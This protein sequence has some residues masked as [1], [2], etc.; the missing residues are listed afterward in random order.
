MRCALGNAFLPTTLTGYPRGG[1][2]PGLPTLRAMTTPALIS[3]RYRLVEEIG[4]GG[5]GVVYRAEDRLTRRQVALKRVVTE[6]PLALSRSQEWSISASGS[7]MFTVVGFGVDSA[8]DADALALAHEFRFLA[9]L[10]HPNIISVLDFGF[11]DHNRPYF[12]MDWL[13]DAQDIVSAAKGRD[14]AGR[15]ELVV[16]LLRA[17]V[18]LHRRGIVHRDLKPSNILVGTDGQVKVL[19]FGI[20]VQAEVQRQEVGVA[21]TAAYMAPEMLGEAPASAVADLYSVGTIMYEM[22]G[23]R[24]A[25]DT[26]SISRLLAQVVNVTPD[27]SL[28]QGSG[29]DDALVPIITRLMSKAPEARYRTAGQTLLAVAE[30]IGTPE[31]A[32]THDSR[33]SL[34]Q[35]ARF[36]GRASELDQL[37]S[38]WRETR[39]DNRTR[40]WLVG[41]E[42]GV[43]KSRLMDE[44]RVYALVTGALVIRGQAVKDAS[45]SYQLWREAARYLALQEELT[46]LDKSVLQAVVPDIAQIVGHPVPPAPDLEAQSAQE[47][48]QRLLV[49]LLKRFTQPTLLI[50]E[51]LQWAGTVSL[52]LLRRAAEEI[53]DQPL[54]I[55]ANYRADEAPQIRDMFVQ[56][57]HMALDR[58]AREQIANLTQ[59]MLGEGDASHTASIV[60]LLHLETSGNAFYV[61][62]AI[63]SL[64]E[65]AGGLENIART[66]ITRDML[67]GALKNLVG[68]RLKGVAPDVGR[69][70]QLAAVH[71]REL[72]IAVLTAL[73]E[74]PETVNRLLGAAIENNIITVAENQY[75]FAHDKIREGVLDAVGAPQRAAMHERLAGAI[76]S[77]HADTLP[78]WAIA[79]AYHWREAGT[80][81]DKEAAYA[82]AAGRQLVERGS[83]REAIPQLTHA[84]DLYRTVRTTDEQVA[85][86]ERA[87][88]EAYFS[89]GQMDRAR[90]HLKR[91]AGLLGAPFP[92]SGAGVLAG[93]IGETVKQ[94]AHRF[95]PQGWFRRRPAAAARALEASLCYERLSHIIFFDNQT[96]PLLYASLRSLNLAENAPPSAEAAR[97]YGT[98]CYSVG[99]VPNYPLAHF[100]D[101]K[102]L[103]VASLLESQGKPVDPWVWEITAYFYSS[104]GDFATA[105]ERYKKGAESALEIGF[106]SRWLECTTLLEMDYYQ[107]GLFEKSA[108][109]REVVHEH[110]LK[111]QNEQAMG[112]AWLGIAEYALL[113]G[114]V[115]KADEFLVKARRVTH[116]MGFTERA[117]M[118]GLVA[119]LH[120][121]RGDY[122][123]MKEATGAALSLLR[124]VPLPNAYY[125]QEGYTAVAE[126][127]L[128]MAEHPEL[129]EADKPQLRRDTRLAM[130]RLLGFGWS[131]P[132]SR[133]HVR[134][135][136]GWRA[137]QRGKQTAARKHWELALT[138]A[139]KFGKVFEKGLAHLDMGRFLPDGH[140][141]LQEAHDIFTRLKFEHHRSL[142]AALIAGRR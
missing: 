36:V 31:A 81:R 137:W 127:C 122:A 121:M 107:M 100:Y 40:F 35:A 117:W 60:D 7:G 45:A 10:R 103:A 96:V 78:E 125:T 133:A 82:A 61:V 79:L 41:G 97:A 77:V 99:L 118:H 108:E 115:A 129:R 139:D 12:T 11:D 5:M 87:L 37:K 20:S 51:D 44:F 86:L 67:K 8:T 69:L 6:A 46:P 65:R 123:G 42:S 2:Y 95:L 75:R 58:L 63:R 104:K 50:L 9:S 84:L 29:F 55:V 90:I 64:A 136:R 113:Q 112:W 89:D 43:G 106:L 15:A 134:R 66:S 73:A 25:F 91:S 56:A 62:E 140:G 114:D 24:H 85:G 38:A 74:S 17:L 76:E 116:R 72:D 19:D 93:L 26:R 111:T 27:F 48:L 33:E 4:E 126:A 57:R 52:S 124:A 1:T 71:G 39:R 130:L 128:A 119:R 13:P 138:E 98:I 70:L 110:A 101:R 22:F 120:T 32:E 83:Y 109:L 18:Y 3:N 53:S 88:G 47:R 59:S 141:H 23:G 142:A 14:A 30:A 131:F 92:V 49:R 34:L 135:I 94:V 68:D 132:A 80:N 54:M 102:A 16:Q 21:G 105:V 28:L